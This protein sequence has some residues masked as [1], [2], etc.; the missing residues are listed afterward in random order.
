MGIMMPQ[1]TQALPVRNTN[2]NCGILQMSRVDMW[3][4]MAQ[5]AQA[6]PGPSTNH[7]CEILQMSRC[8]LRLCQ[9]LLVGAAVLNG[10]VGAA[11][12]NGLY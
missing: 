9:G 11:V 4:M 8:R 12:L 10:L 7:N 5:E 3:I 2:H 1:E 6:L